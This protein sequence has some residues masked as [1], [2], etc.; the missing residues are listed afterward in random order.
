MLH[1]FSFTIQGLIDVHMWHIDMW[2]CVLVV[3]YILLDKVYQCSLCSVCAYWWNVCC[4]TLLWSY[5]VNAKNV[6]I[7]YMY[8]EWVNDPWKKWKKWCYHR[9]LNRTVLK[10]VNMLCYILNHLLLYIY[11][12]NSNRWNTLISVVSPALKHSLKQ[13]KKSVGLDIVIS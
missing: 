10:C 2:K 3:W 13:Q 6:G 5:W 9:T 11:I 1:H 4:N 7:I 8:T 12:S